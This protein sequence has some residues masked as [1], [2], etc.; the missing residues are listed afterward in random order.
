MTTVEI[1]HV[2]WQQAEDWLGSLSD[3]QRPLEERKV[4][5]L[6]GIMERG[7]FVLTPD[8]VVRVNKKVFNGQHR[9]AA[10][11]RA[12]KTCPYLLFMSDNEIIHDMFEHGVIQALAD[13]N[14]LLIT[15]GSLTLKYAK[16][17][18]EAEQAAKRISQFGSHP[19]QVVFSTEA[20]IY[21]FHNW[22]KLRFS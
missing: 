6:A 12:K 7:E 20:L 22:R 10:Q 15:V 13:P 14:P 1:C 3:S 5:E 11:V 19:I 9:L 4:A 2:L 8:T 17:S 21:M 16:D 18:P